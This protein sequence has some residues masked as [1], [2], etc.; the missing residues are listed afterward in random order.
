MHSEMKKYLLINIK[1][2][3]TLKSLDCP[4]NTSLKICLEIGVGT[5]LFQIPQNN[6]MDEVILLLQR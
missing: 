2:Y 6:V 3:E 5:V 1:T 4:L